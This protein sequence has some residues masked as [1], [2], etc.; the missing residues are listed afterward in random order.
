M[1]TLL[2]ILAIVLCLWTIRA[3][4][5]FGVSR[6]LVKY[7]LVIQD[8]DAARQAT[9]TAPQDAQTHIAAATIASL[10]GNTEESIAALEHAAAVRPAD[11]SIW[12][13]LG[14][15]R[16]EA[17]D[18]PGALAAFDEAV[19]RAPFYARPRW[20][21]G[22][23]LLRAG[24][25]DEAFRDL[26]QAATSNPELVPR[27][28]DLAWSVSLGDPDTTE[29]LMPMNAPERRIAFARLLAREHRFPDAVRQFALSG[30]NN[31]EIASELVQELLSRGG[32]AEAYEV[33]KTTAPAGSDLNS[34][35]YDG[36]FEGP[37]LKDERAFGWRVTANLKGARVMPDATDRQSGAT[38]LL[39][40]FEGELNSAT[41]LSQ[42]V[43]VKP[44]TRY[45]IS[46]ATKAKNIVSGGPPIVNVIDASGQ[47]LLAKSE[48]LNKDFGSWR[49][50]SFE[51]TTDDNMRAVMIN[52][53][54]ESC[55][56][57]TC[58]IFGS[59]SLDSFSLTPL[60]DKTR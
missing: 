22:N 38:S 24:R 31:T 57:A 3:S 34:L 15:K 43:I 33:W 19:R 9:Q 48:A 6:A 55:T 8:A 29:Q 37:L 59:L 25:R 42:L 49:L 41:L 10:A 14:I 39:I 40:E 54:R 26:G 56:T 18:K 32:Y 58:P 21:R 7:S 2:V 52:L 12:L 28:I 60:D 27:L 51:F 1:K 35:I 45:Q 46:F 20:Q 4:A 30:R 11:H 5:V 13:A 44:A 50:I 17:G 53:G 16:D 36:G 47:Q 23:L